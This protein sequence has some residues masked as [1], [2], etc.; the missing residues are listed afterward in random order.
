MGDKV[1]GRIRGGQADY[2]AVQFAYRLAH[3]LRLVKGPQQPTGLFH[4]SGAGGKTLIQGP[5]L[6]WTDA[7]AAFEAD[8]PPSKGGV[9]GGGGAG[10]ETPGRGTR[11]GAQGNKAGGVGYGDYSLHQIGHQVNLAR[12]LGA[13]VHN[14]VRPAQRDPPEAGAGLSDVHRGQV[15]LGRFHRGNYLERTGRQP[16]LPFQL[17]QQAGGFGHFLC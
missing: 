5:D 12:G 3:A 10:Q 17:G 8:V 16:P 6:V 11:P 15:S 14:Q 4:F 13:Q 1:T 2:P 9:A 7:K